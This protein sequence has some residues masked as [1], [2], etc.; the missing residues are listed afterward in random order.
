MG[1]K[2]KTSLNQ[3]RNMNM[4]SNNKAIDKKLKSFL[5]FKDANDKIDFDAE[6][7]HLNIINEI[8]KLMVEQGM[9]KAKLAAKLKTSKS[10][11]TQLF[12]GDKLFN[13]KL[14]AKL[15]NI[16]KVKFHLRCDIIDEC[17]GDYKS[18]SK[19]ILNLYSEEK[20]ESLK[21]ELDD[22][23]NEKIEYNTIKESIKTLVG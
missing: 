10:Y 18:Y 3:Y 15:Q 23:Y 7:I 16:F 6:V 2:K 5:E 4:N 20:I 13:P 19:N 11:I 14:L 21:N 22:D 12:S 17:Y 9:N 1:K 8:L